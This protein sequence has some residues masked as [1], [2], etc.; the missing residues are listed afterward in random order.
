MSKTAYLFETRS[1]QRFLF[2]G[3]KLRDMVSASD[4]L[5]ALCAEG[6]TISQYTL[7]SENAWFSPLDQTLKACEIETDD[8]QFSRRAGGAIYVVFSAESKARQFQI[9]WS[10][11]VRQH[12][13]GV[14]L[15]QVLE[16]AD[17]VPQ[18]MARALEQLPAQRNRV[19]PQLPVPGPLVRRSPRTGEPAV[20]YD[21]SRGEWVDDATRIK[22]NVKPS[23]SSLIPKFAD[24]FD[25]YQWPNNLE[26]ETEGDK[27][28]VTFPFIGEER[29]VALVHADGNG[30]GEVLMKLGDTIKDVVKTTGKEDQYCELFLQFSRAMEA[31]TAAAA[32]RA[33][34]VV[35][36]TLNKGDVVPA[37]PLVLG[38][39]DLTLLIRADL[40]LEFTNSFCRA[41]EEETASRL[42][43]L[44]D[45]IDA[46]VPDHEFDLTRLTRLTA[47]AGVAFIKANQPFLQAHDLAESLCGE[48]KARSREHMADS[49]ELIDAS[50]SFH[51]VSAALIEKI[52]DVR[53]HEW[54]L[55]SIARSVIN[56]EDKDKSV[57]LAMGGY[58]LDEAAQRSTQSTAG[59]PASLPSYRILTELA[60]MFSENGLNR[61]GL[62]QVA[63]LLKDNPDLARQRY[64][65]WREVS[66]KSQPGELQNFDERMAELIALQ[67]ADDLPFDRRTGKSPLMDLLVITGFSKA[68]TSP[69]QGGAHE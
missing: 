38:G 4:Q 68:E 41:F 69:E 32:K 63:M 59:Q 66:A 6:R 22:R 44:K 37:R 45:S 54:T 30:I 17:T 15:V 53:E 36:D 29:T 34:R 19:S 57:E 33:M 3:G 20:T 16:T 8:V 62:R 35:L 55:P 51:Q 39:D 58:A 56:F 27:S 21:R 10:Y 26:R 2:E 50:I 13:P 18:A 1:V 28:G 49:R 43:A 67:S 9:C 47:S 12:F 61:N 48:A 23:Q 14:E 5:D 64:R 11:Y 46:L 60:G 40:A 52:K 7:N 42:S 65:R 31:S 24:D 25:Q